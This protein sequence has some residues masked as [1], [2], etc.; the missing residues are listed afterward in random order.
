M[1]DSSKYEYISQIVCEINCCILLYL[2]I[3]IYVIYLY[4]FI[5]LKINLEYYL[6]LF[7]WI[8]FFQYLEYIGIK[9][10][11][12]VRFLPVLYSR[13]FIITSHATELMR[14]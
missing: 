4:V 5:C 9:S 13:L 6:S 1:S 10:K 12:I 2:Y 11:N 14:V 7:Y 3:F 8:H